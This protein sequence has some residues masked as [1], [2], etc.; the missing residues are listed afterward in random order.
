MA[1]RIRWQLVI[2]AFSALLIAGLLGRLALRTTSLDSPLAGGV[3]TEAVV[4]APQL[5]IPLLNDPLADP[6][7]RDLIN[8]VFDGLVRVGAD[9][10]IEPALAS[11]QVDPT[12]TTYIFTL[13]RDA[14]W[15]D[16]QP[17]TAADVVF[18]L[19][20][21]QLLAQPGD[22]LL[23][24]AWAPQLIDRL[25][26]FT[27]RVTLA[28]PVASFPNLARVPILPAHL[29]AA[30]PPEQWPD[31]PFATQPIGTGPFRLVE[32]REDG[33][34]LVANETHFNGRP[35]LDR[36]EVRFLASAEA[37]Q[38]ALL[39]GSVM[40]FGE[41]LGPNALNPNLPA[42]LRSSA[43]PLDEYATLSFN[44]RG[45]PFAEQ[46]LR[47]ALAHGLNK[48]AL[49]ERAMNG[50]AA[51]L[52]TPILPGSW[53]FDPEV[54]WYAPDQATATRLLGELGWQP[55]PDGVRSRQGQRLQF[56]L[57]VDAEPRRRAAATEIARQWAELGVVANVIEL[58]GPDLQARLRS[59]DFAV[60]LHAWSRIGPD[61]DVFALWHSQSALNYAGLN[62][63]QLDNLLITARQ[64]TELA[65]RSADYAAFQRRW[66]ELVPAIS[67]YQPLFAFSADRQLGGLGLDDP[68]S[69]MNALLFGPEDRYRT[70]ARWYTASYREIQGE[71]R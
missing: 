50:N 43:V 54:T 18:T 25:D 1:R 9:G 36:L 69:A 14:R 10:L 62:D 13:R 12:G 65:A 53:A 3:L 42:N 5:L 44:L 16:G 34:S 7:G 61:P 19:R 23:A 48:E 27:I 22:P 11:Y 38:A 20:T 6:V 24:D 70:V 63:P 31:L 41:R 67:L 21:L 2:A 4:G 59:G 49:V 33:V 71:V 52:D 40:A 47:R 46:P 60:A 51:P 55:E 29:L 28:E 39:R 17:V 56:D 66:V 45:D 32:L 58:S 64:E 26:D 8:L 57:L 68:A 35:F 15:H 30:T 37:A